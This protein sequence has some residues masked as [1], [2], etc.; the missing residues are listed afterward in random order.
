[1]LCQHTVPVTQQRFGS[2]AYSGG[3]CVVF[4]HRHTHH[5]AIYYSIVTVYTT[6]STTCDST[7][8]LVVLAANIGPRNLLPWIT[9]KSM[10]MVMAHGAEGVLIEGGLPVNQVL[11]KLYELVEDGGPATIEGNTTSVPPQDTQMTDN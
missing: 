11:T 9:T 8:A 4:S 2:I 3:V 1:M 10:A 6:T 7:H 5:P